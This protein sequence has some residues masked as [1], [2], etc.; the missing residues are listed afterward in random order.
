MRLNICAV[1]C[2][3]AEPPDQSGTQN[4]VRCNKC[5]TLLLFDSFGRLNYSVPTSLETFLGQNRIFSTVPENALKMM[6]ESVARENF[7]VPIATRDDYLIVGM[8]HPILDVVDKLRFVLNRN[9]LA[10]KIS[11][12]TFNGLIHSYDDIGGAPDE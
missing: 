4:F 12:D 8:V 3:A 2:E 1:C 7:A 9:I 11:D 10:V 5:G 6:P